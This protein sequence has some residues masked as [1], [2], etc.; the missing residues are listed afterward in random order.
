MSVLPAD[1]VR[2]FTDAAASPD[3]DLAAPALLIARLGYPSLDPDPYLARLE[4]MGGT[5][6]DRLRAAPRVGPPGGPSTPSTGSS[7]RTRASA[8]TRATT[9]TRATAS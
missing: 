3:P 1:V 7:S 6:A 9:T 2:R 5:A 4:A 8:A